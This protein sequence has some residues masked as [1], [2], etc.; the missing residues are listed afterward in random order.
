MIKW[1]RGVR[2]N[3]KTGVFILVLA[4]LMWAMVVYVNIRDFVPKELT[5]P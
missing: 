5:Q 2:L 4:A 3:F 1:I